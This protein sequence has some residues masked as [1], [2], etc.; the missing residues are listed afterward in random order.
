MDADLSHVRQLI[1]SSATESEKVELRRKW[2]KDPNQGGT[3]ISKGNVM[4]SFFIEL[5]DEERESLEEAARTQ[6]QSAEQTRTRLVKSN[7]RELSKQFAK[8]IDG[9]VARV[10]N[11]ELVF[12]LPNSNYFYA[13]SMDS[14]NFLLSV[15][16]TPVEKFAGNGDAVRSLAKVLARNPQPK[17]A[18]A[19]VSEV[20]AETKLRDIIKRFVSAFEELKRV[21]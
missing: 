6:R 10:L 18:I 8:L 5:V 14:G 21:S 3:L 2:L 15:D 12:E 7:E 13:V 1:Y 20:T 19:P 4:N 16:N 11:G 9:N 17:P